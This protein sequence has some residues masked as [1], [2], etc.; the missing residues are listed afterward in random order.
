MKINLYA[1][2]DVKAESADK[3]FVCPNDAVAIRSIKELIDKQEHFQKNY[4]DYSLMRVGSFEMETAELKGEEKA[5]T[6][7]E[8]KDLIEKS[9]KDNSDIEKKI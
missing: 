2:Y 5:V 7:I 1:I 8:F 3:P 9:K 4:D 6:I